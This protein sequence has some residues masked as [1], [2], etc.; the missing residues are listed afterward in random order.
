MRIDQLIPLHNTLRNPKRVKEFE[1]RLRMGHI[2]RGIETPIVISKIEESKLESFYEGQIYGI[3][4]RY[5]IHDGHHRIYAAWLCGIKELMSCEYIM[6]DMSYE[7]YQD[8][9]PAVG[10]VTPIDIKIHVRKPDFYHFKNAA[11]AIY[12]KGN[13]GEWDYECKQYVENHIDMYQEDRTVWSVKD[14]K[15][16]E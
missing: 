14:M 12:N 7:M 8:L 11:L 6:R 1:H 15:Y 13:H 16:D 2:L 5:Y 9:N 3:T 4:D 10:W